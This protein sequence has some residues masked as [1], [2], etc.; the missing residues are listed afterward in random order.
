MKNS[1]KVNK[2]G[3]VFCSVVGQSEILRTASHIK[4][5]GAKKDAPKSAN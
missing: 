1:K 3:N 5:T 2:P 4:I